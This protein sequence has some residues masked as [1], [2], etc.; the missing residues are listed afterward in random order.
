MRICYNADFEKY[1][2][3]KAVLS[4]SL[5]SYIKKTDQQKYAY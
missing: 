5:V 4:T 1:G 3:I 2:R